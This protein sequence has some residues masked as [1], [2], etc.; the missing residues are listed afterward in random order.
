M[1]IYKCTNERTKTQEKQNILQSQTQKKKNTTTRDKNM[2]ILIGLLRFGENNN[3]NNNNTIFF[4]YLRYF[5]KI[6]T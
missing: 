3:N 4:F 5:N 2:T 6:G 1:H